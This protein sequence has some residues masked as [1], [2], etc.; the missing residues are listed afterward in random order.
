MLPE[1]RFHFK[2]VLGIPG[3]VYLAFFYGLAILLVLFFILIKPGLSKPGTL[4]HFDSEPQ[5]AAIRIDGAY[6]SSAPDTIFIPPGK[7]E[8][9]MVLPGFA[10]YKTELETK[11]RV[12]ASLFFPRRQ[13]VNGKLEIQN[14]EGVF[15]LGAQDYAAWSFIGEATAAY[16]IPRSL[17]EAAYL[18]AGGSETLL[19]ASARFASTRSGLR[20]LLR[21]KL[22]ADNAGVSPSPLSLLRSGESILAYLSTAE[23]AASWLAAVLP[24]ASAAPLTSSVWYAEKTASVTGQKLLP[25]AGRAIT[26]KSVFFREIPP[27]GFFIAD[28]PVSMALWEEFLGANPDWQPQETNNLIAKGLVDPGYLEER[29]YGPPETITGVSWYAAAAFCRWLNSATGR[30]NVPAGFIF[31]LPTEAEWEYAAQVMQRENSDFWDWCEDPFA[32]LNLPAAVEAVHALGSPQRSL[33]GGSWINP[34]GSVNVNTRASLDPASCSPFVSFR[35]VL[36]R[37]IPGAD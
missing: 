29:E 31:R 4:V 14:A 11:G 7:H 3:G 25:P 2:P 28:T 22:L 12:F 24:P 9:E 33:R 1:D 13:S 26:I 5:G 8:V 6:Q 10:P 32:P 36:A 30:E 23:G 19:A 16:Q 20:D 18:S 35:P 15:N 34:P 21:A 27:E 37:P 17:S